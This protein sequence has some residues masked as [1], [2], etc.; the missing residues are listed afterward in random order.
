MNTPSQ[1]P[2]Q[3]HAAPREVL[4]F[5]MDGQE[6][7][8]DILVVQEIRSNSAVTRIPDAPAYVKGVLNL[9]GKVLPVI[10]LRLKL[11]LAAV[12]DDA[13]VMIVFDFGGSSI[14]AVVDSVSDVLQLDAGQILPPPEIAAIDRRSLVGIVVVG[15]RNLVL[16]DVEALLKEPQAAVAA[17]LSEAA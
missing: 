11:R 16:L 17:G 3:P 13:T 10:D 4:T 1:S 8:V 7:G 14:G 2:R 15:E 5:R 12:D 9:R 6:Y